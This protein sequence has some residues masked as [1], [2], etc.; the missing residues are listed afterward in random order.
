[1]VH[2]DTIIKSIEDAKSMGMKS[3]LVGCEYSDTVRSRFAAKGWNMWSCDLLPTDNPDNEKHYQGN[4]L[5]LLGLDWDLGIFHPPCTYLT[6]SQAWTFKRLDKFPD[7]HNQRAE[8]IAFCERI[9]DCSIPKKVIE[10]PVGFLS[11]M[12]KLG[13]KYQLIQPYNFGDDASKRTCLWID[14]LPDLRGT[15]YVDPRIVNGLPRWG[16]QTDSGQ[17]KI[18]P[19]ADRWKKRSDTFPGIAD[20]MA[21]QWESLCMSTQLEISFK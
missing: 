21:D 14:G 11:T 20:A 19:S 1:M 5:D 9:W 2:I 7:R 3:G 16:N 15:K 17:N 12:S 13:K 18:G 6:V 8:A 10:N 4:V